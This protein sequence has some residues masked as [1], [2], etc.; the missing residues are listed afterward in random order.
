[1]S[2]DKQRYFLEISYDGTNY[3]GLQI[4][5]HAVSI[6]QVINEGLSTILNTAE[7][8][9]TICASRTDSGVHAIQNFLHFDTE[10][11]IPEDFLFRIN[12]L[13]PKDIVIKKIIPVEPQA[14]CRFDAIQRS[15]E[16]IVYF[17]KDP[18]MQNRGYQYSIISYQLSVKKEKIENK[19]L[20]INKM[21]RAAKLL[22]KH[23]DY[24]AFCKA[25]TDVKSKICLITHAK[26]TL[27]SSRQTVGMNF[28]ISSNRFLRGMV[29]ALVGTL[30]R[31]GTGEHSVEDFRKI[32][33]GKDRS[34]VDF[35]PPPQGLYLKEVKYRDI[36]MSNG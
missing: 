29:R 17:E 10:Q 32:I 27:D 36:F 2:A 24:T 15:Y 23:K 30:L 1:M 5:K 9:K 8:V 35:S 4:Q 31:V 21:N 3:K 7:L 19:K 33:E 16:Y 20:D 14:H 22:K 11:A 25:K 18:F 28:S 26:W 13:I 34:K 12:C 6:Q